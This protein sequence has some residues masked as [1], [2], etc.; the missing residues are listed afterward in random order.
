MDSEIAR[1]VSHNCLGGRP[2]PRSL[3]ILW[4]N[5]EDAEDALEIHLLDEPDWVDDSAD[6]DPHVRANVQAH[7][8]M[9]Q[10]IGFFA[11]GDEGELY[12]Y[13]WGTNSPE[14]PV[15]T[16]DSE[17]SY[18][19]AGIDL[20]EAML[21]R[22]HREDPD[23]DEQYDW[24]YTE[25]WL[26]QHNLP[27][28]E[29]TDLGATTQFLP[30]L[31]DMHSRRYHELVG[32]PRPAVT[33]SEAPADPADPLSWLMRPADEVRAAMTA[34][35]G[36]PPTE[37]R[38]WTLGDGLVESVMFDRRMPVIPVVLG[39]TVGSTRDEVRQ[40]LGHGEELAPVR[41]RYPRGD[42]T[43]V[44]QFDSQDQ[45]EWIALRSGLPE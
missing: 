45:V 27:T 2:L 13:W 23:E 28:A 14:P 43:V 34:L 24:D 9:F 16:L 37:H 15:V 35:L 21:A 26:N 19:W 4:E 22:F 20:T 5:D 41:R 32:D 44:V 40:C 25:N 12:G 10:K 42:R 36:A 17:G 7:R 8:E 30:N 18:E 3:E 11:K 6:S 31:A 1:R 33:P 29:L 39:V 38:V